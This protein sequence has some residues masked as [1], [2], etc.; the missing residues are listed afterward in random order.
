MCTADSDSE[1][2]WPGIFN[3]DPEKN[4]WLSLLHMDY[5]NIIVSVLFL[6][7]FAKVLNTS[8]ELFLLS[9]I[10]VERYID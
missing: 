1:Q 8:H 4:S 5:V 10:R 7:I 2:K 9:F 3:F 6:V